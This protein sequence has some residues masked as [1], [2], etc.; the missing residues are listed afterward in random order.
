MHVYSTYSTG[1][2]IKGYN[3][4]EGWTS[5]HYLSSFAPPSATSGPAPT[6]GAGGTGLI[7]IVGAEAVPTASTVL[8]P[9][10]VPPRWGRS[11]E[12]VP[13][14]QSSRAAVNQ[15]FVEFAVVIL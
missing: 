6:G 5:E 14:R 2:G 4:T 8:A 10:R 13:P 11:D 7:P 3:P 1:T 12:G 15:A 9:C